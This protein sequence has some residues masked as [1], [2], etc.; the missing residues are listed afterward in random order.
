LVVEVEDLHILE[1]QLVVDK[2]V[3]QLVVRD[4]EPL[5][6]LEV[7]EEHNLLVVLADLLGVLLDQHFK[8][9]QELLVMETLVVVAADITVVAVEVPLVKTVV[10]EEGVGM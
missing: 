4:L 2:V 9:D 6:V 8:V 1:L 5:L 10:V 3:E 7:K